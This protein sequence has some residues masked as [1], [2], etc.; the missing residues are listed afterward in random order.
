MA[1]KKTKMTKKAKKQVKR[2]SAVKAERHLTLARKWEST[3]LVAAIACA[4]IAQMSCP[5]SVGAALLKRLEK[6]RLAQQAALARVEPA[7]AWEADA[8]PLH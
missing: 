1:K 3:D 4:N 2:P 8:S 5:T 7:L 6:K